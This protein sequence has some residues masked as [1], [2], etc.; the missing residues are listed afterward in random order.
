MSF[1]QS[2]S[3]LHTRRSDDARLDL[4]SSFLNLLRVLMMHSVPTIA[5]HAP[6]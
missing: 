5:G 4:L 1:F 3:S 6:R 2:N